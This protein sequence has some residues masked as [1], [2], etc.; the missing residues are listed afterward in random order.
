MASW[1]FDSYP[2]QLQDMTA[3]SAV[4]LFEA[5]ERKGAQPCVGGGWGV[6]ALLGR[7]TRDH[8]DLDLMLPAADLELLFL[9]FTERGV[10]RIL[11]RRSGLIC[12]TPIADGSHRTR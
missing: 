12:Q 3:E 6:D 10:D 7:Q 1:K 2:M 8:S 9:A 5:L 4:E 11:P